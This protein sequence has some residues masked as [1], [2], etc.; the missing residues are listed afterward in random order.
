MD[1]PPCRHACKKDSVSISLMWFCFLLTLPTFLPLTCLLLLRL[2][3]FLSSPAAAAATTICFS[4]CA[5]S[6]LQPARQCCCLLLKAPSQFHRE[7]QSTVAVAVHNSLQLRPGEPVLRMLPQQ[8]QT[9]VLQAPR[10]RPARAVAEQHRHTPR[11][12]MLL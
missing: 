12:A 7:R 3:P 11:R 1:S 10:S 2:A 5:P 8:P 9:P 6:F 4:F